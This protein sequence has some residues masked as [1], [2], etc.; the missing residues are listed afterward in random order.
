L[1]LFFL[2]HFNFALALKF[3]LICKNSNL[4]KFNSNKKKVS[5]TFVQD[6]TG[7]INENPME[8]TA[9][10]VDTPDIAPFRY[11]NE[12]V[13]PS[14]P[15]VQKATSGNASDKVGHLEP[16]SPVRRPVSVIKKTAQ[17]AQQLP[18]MSPLRLT[19][20]EPNGQQQQQH[21]ASIFIEDLQLNTYAQENGNQSKTVTLI[22]P[23]SNKNNNNNII[24][25]PNSSQT[26]SSSDLHN[27]DSN[28]DSGNDIIDDENDDDSNLNEFGLKQQTHNYGIRNLVVNNGDTRAS[29]L[30]SKKLKEI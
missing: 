27:I 15:L 25:S 3:I 24:V 7:A 17:I 29:T 4:F 28:E 11:R 13:P 2:N 26:V 6:S 23:L 1:P 12:S 18:P 16:S 10:G 19:S 8:V 14:I 22:N 20:T 30:P 9:V 21:R 5:D